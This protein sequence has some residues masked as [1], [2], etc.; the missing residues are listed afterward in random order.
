MVEFNALWFFVLVTNFIVLAVLLNFIL[1]KPLI[2]L[3]KERQRLKDESANEV[4]ALN[5]KRDVA[6]AQL[7][8]EMT[9]ASEKA[10]EEFS[11]LKKEG[12][13]VQAEMISKAQA[14]AIERLSAALKEISSEAAAA[15]GKLKAGIALLS[16][17]IVNKLM[18]DHIKQN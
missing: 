13:T 5:E 6:F 12:L 9:A 16:A 14:E 8:E 2:F 11:R 10:K 18:Y 7:K 17:T 1:F 4:K 3:L 15:K